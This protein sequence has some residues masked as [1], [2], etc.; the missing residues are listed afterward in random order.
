MY[1]LSPQQSIGFKLFAKI[2]KVSCVFCR[3][4]FISFKPTSHPKVNGFPCSIKETNR[5]LN[6]GMRVLLFDVFNGCSLVQLK[7]NMG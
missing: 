4:N 3:S 2:M 7:K 6:K 1:L 5:L